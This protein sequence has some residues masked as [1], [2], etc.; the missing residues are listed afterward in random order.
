MAV[1][2]QLQFTAYKPSAD[3]SVPENIAEV[4]ASRLAAGGSYPAPQY[5]VPLF[6]GQVREVANTVSYKD[7]LAWYAAGL[8]TANPEVQQTLSGARQGTRLG[9]GG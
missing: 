3:C 5:D 6:K 4:V 7:R 2:T 8:G 9:M 1:W